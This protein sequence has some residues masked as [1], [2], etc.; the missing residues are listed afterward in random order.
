MADETSA[1]EGGVNTRARKNDPR[2]RAGLRVGS[3][4][5]QSSTLDRVHIDAQGR[6]RLGRP[7][8]VSQWERGT[9][10]F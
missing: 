7:R 1:L 2:P 9:G 10:G 4:F 8:L 3:A 5:A 6:A